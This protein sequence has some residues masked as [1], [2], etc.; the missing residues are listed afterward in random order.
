[1]F[2]LGRGQDP[3]RRW[4]SIAAV[5][6]AVALLV[7]AC[8]APATETPGGQPTPAATSGPDET[9]AAVA[10]DLVI[11]TIGEPQALRGEIT[12]KEPNAPGTRNVFEQL[13]TLDPSTGQLAPLL[14]LS[15][16]R[17]SPTTWRFKLREGVT[18]HDGSPFNAES[19]A[20]SI[21]YW[22][23]PENKFVIRSVMAT[24][25]TAAVVDE[26]TIDVSTTG[27]DPILPGRLYLAGIQSMKQLLADPDGSNEEPIGTG[28]YK[29]VEWVQGQYW[30]VESNPDWWGLTADDAPGVPPYQRIRFTPR[31]ED[32]IRAGAALQG[33]V[34]IAMY[35]TPESCA[36][37]DAAP[38]VKCIAV[39]S[40]FFFFG[41]LD[42][43]DAHPALANAKVREAIFTAIDVAAIRE[44]I[45]GLAEPLQGQLLPPVAMGFNDSLQ[46]YPYDPGRAAQLIDEARAE[47]V[48]VDS[49]VV[50]V[51]ARQATFPRADEI[52]EAVGGM[53]TAA[54]IANEVAFEEPGVINP[55]IATKPVPGEDRAFLLLHPDSSP[56]LDYSTVFRSWITCGSAISV[57]CDPDF[58]ERLAAAE[59]LEGAE[60]HAA[61]E[62]LVQEVHD[63]YLHLPIAG[64]VR[65][66]I[67]PENLEW[68]LGVDN[69]IQAVYMR[70]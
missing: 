27:A 17:V 18:F 43:T 46:P 56:L 54:G 2:R 38:G 29:F 12:F 47:G 55:R 9:G 15:W 44:A 11:A 3:R 59:A 22:F 36:E 64:V 58:D 52:A 28:P 23:D 8:G 67:V 16:E 51:A 10:Q 1:M 50:Y 66:Y 14:A 70:P 13:T 65:A 32:A 42:F 48:D 40:D 39:G 45:I 30:E 7:G 41:R 6:T 24:Q 57:Y 31:P 21:N 62:A 61:F 25:I 37:A 49:L 5:T 19:A 20:F 53:L 35:V 4:V 33:E 34:D 26:F 69:R 68:T 60:R 63:L